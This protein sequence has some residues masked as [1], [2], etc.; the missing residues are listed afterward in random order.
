VGIG[1]RSNFRVGIFIYMDLPQTNAGIPAPG[2]DPTVEELAA[3]TGLSGIFD[4]LGI[5]AA[6]RTSLLAAMGGGQPQ[7]RDVVYIKG[8]D[9]D[10]AIRDLAIPAADGQGEAR[11]PTPFELGHFAMVRRIARLRLG[12]PANEAISSGLIS[13][14]FGDLSQGLG[15]PSQPS[16]LSTVAAPPSAPASTEPKTKLSVI[17]DPSLDSELVRLP[18]SKVRAL[19]NNYATLRG[20]EPSEDVEPTVEQVSAFAQLL[21][22]DMVPYADFSLFGPH[23]RRLLQKLSYLSW[24]F[25]PDG[26]WHRKEL[27]GPPTFEH[28][29]SS[30][31]VLRVAYLLLDVAPPELLDNYGEMLRGF[32]TL[33]GAQA[34]FI[35]YSADVRMRSEQFDRVRRYAERDHDKAV[36]EGIT[37]H[38]DPSKPWHTIFRAAI[39]DKLWWDENLHRPAVLFLTKVKSAPETINDGTVQQLEGGEH[40]GHLR[41]RSRSRRRLQG[42]SDRGHRRGSGG[43]TYTKKGHRFCDAFNT[44]AGCSLPGCEDFHGCKKCKRT[45]HGIH[46]CNMEKVNSVRLTPAPPMPPAVQSDH[47]RNSGKGGKGKGKG[48]Y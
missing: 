2:I 6:T 23:G 14:P 38:F 41:Q 45:G 8:G 27:P 22:A 20:A 31:R 43:G 28:W 42:T 21:A 13:A 30:F 48:K 39:E 34:W 4:W 19:F 32:S 3:F 5:A 24:T 17:L 47:W 18:H 25:Q 40:S 37:T 29:W 9:W 12:L 36:Q 16:Q 1:G 7:M 35:V 26:T 11:G 33:Y 10:K 46:Q 15:Q 44:P